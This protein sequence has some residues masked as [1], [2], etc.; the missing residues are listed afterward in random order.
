MPLLE[1]IY[2]M[3]QTIHGEVQQNNNKTKSYKVELERTKE[4]VQALEDGQN[5]ILIELQS[6]VN[7]NV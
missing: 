7:K 4:R 1:D 2:T 6:F 5:I 3:L